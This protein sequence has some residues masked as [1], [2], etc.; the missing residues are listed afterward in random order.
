MFELLGKRV[1]E[2]VIGLQGDLWSIG[3]EKGFY[4]AEFIT[5]SASLSRCF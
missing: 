2:E 4:M 5:V 3:E 1:F